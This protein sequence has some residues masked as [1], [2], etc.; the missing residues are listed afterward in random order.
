MVKEVEVG[1]LPGHCRAGRASM[2]L[3][4]CQISRPDVLVLLVF[5]TAPE[6]SRYR[7]DL[8]CSKGPQASSV[9]SILRPLIEEHPTHRRQ[10]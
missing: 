5:E 6:S 8:L 3:D 4:C 1:A 10:S 2:D 9:Q 7:Q